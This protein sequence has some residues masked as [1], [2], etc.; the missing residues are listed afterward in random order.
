[1]TSGIDHGKSLMGSQHV[2]FTD[3]SISEQFTSGDV[4]L[5]NTAGEIRRIPIPS[6]DPNDPLNFTK[7]RKLGILVCCCWFSVFSLVLVGGLGP[8]LGDFI[9]AYTPGK[10]IQQVFNL[11]TFPS[12]VMAF[13]QHDNIL[14]WKSLANMLDREFPHPSALHDIWQAT[15]LP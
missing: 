10:T 5:L 12:L 7:A 15:S 13:G 3:K 14:L 9:A 11:T 2:E 4:Q 8:I 6:N 1:M